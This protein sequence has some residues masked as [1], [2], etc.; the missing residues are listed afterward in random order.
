MALLQERWYGIA[1][2]LRLTV[3]L[4][5]DFGFTDANISADNAIL[6]IAYYLHQRELPPNFL[7]SEAH[8]ADRDAI[9]RWLIR[10]LL[11]SGVWGSGLD[12]LLTALRSTIKEHGARA[13]PVDAIESTMR[14]R[15]KR[16]LLD[17]EE[18]QDLTDIKYGDRR[19]FP[20]LSL[21]YPFVD[22]RNVFHIDHVFPRSRFSDARLGGAGVDPE[23]IWRFKDRV[24]R[25]SN[26]QLLDGPLNQSKGDQLP[27][28]WM[29]SHFPDLQARE[30]YVARHDLGDVPELVGE[31]NGFY[32]ARQERLLARLGNLLAEESPGG[33]PIPPPLT[34]NH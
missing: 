2:A 11:K 1:D 5:A 9:R 25:L 20:L 10:S 7:H 13:F 28:D 19:V 22:F 26:L 29:V 27:A 3:R 17:E 6:P 4:V 24:D 12:T 21:L 34:L 14:A 32:E 8:Q 31:F 23:D 30:A 16:L 18:L 33:T 15:G